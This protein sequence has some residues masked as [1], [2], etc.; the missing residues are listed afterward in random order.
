[1]KLQVNGFTGT[2]LFLFAV[3]VFCCFGFVA[4]AQLSL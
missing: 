1:M 3:M 4:L 2:V